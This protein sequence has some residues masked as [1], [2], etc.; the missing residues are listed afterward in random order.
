MKATI[1]RME[2]VHMPLYSV[3]PMLWRC[4]ELCGIHRVEIATQFGVIRIGG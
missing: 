1:E 3:T 4:G 2:T